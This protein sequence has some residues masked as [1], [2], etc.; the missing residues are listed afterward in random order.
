MC[1]VASVYRVGRFLPLAVQ[2]KD[3][4]QFTI[5]PMHTRYKSYES[6]RSLANLLRV[7]LLC[8]ADG[9]RLSCELSRDGNR[10]SIQTLSFT[11]VH[12]ITGRTNEVV[13]AAERTRV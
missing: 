3:D 8:L 7:H 13:K 5:F 6:L 9:A 12:G 1:L 4:F 2:Y 10:T 11:S